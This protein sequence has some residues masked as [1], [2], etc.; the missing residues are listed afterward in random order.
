M[1]DNNNYYEG[2]EPEQPQE[3]NEP[4][5]PNQ[6]SFFAENDGSY[7]MTT[8]E[9][10]PVVLNPV[11]E[12]IRYKKEKKPK[13]WLV[14]AASAIAGALIFSFCAP[15]VSSLTKPLFSQ[16]ESFAF[17]VPQHANNDASV[18]P[19]THSTEDRHQMTAV[20]IGKT[21]GPSIVGIITKKQ[22]QGFFSQQS[23]EENGS[24]IIFTAAGH[25]VTNYHVIEGATNVS[26]VLNNGTEYNATL[27]GSDE[28]T[29]LAVIKIDAPDLTPAVLGDSSSLEAGEMVVAIGNPMGLEFAG[30][31]T[32]GIISA[33]NRTLTVSGRTYKLIQ[34]DA[35]INPGNSGGALVNAY[36]EVIGI[37]S[38]KVASSGVEGMGFAIP[39]SDAKPIIEDLMNNGY[40]T[41]RPL[42]GL[43]VRYIT[44]Q[45]AYY[46]N[47]AT[48][49]L[50]VVEVTPGSGAEAAGIQKGDIVVSCD[51]QEV[52]SSNELNEIRDQHKAGETIHLVINRNGSVMNVD[53]VL[54]EESKT[55]FLR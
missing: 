48:K 28:R 11:H 39:I 23:A 12:N 29:D 10:Y 41:G 19:V 26:V 53:V 55:S 45:E 1:M 31:L 17:S 5:D 46:Y 9:A 30:S 7:R 2:F 34:T 3:A 15:V 33:V 22:Y 52:T 35:A 4:Q 50:V 51:G 24:G 18:T 49:G 42:I 13:I 25:I 38:V 54:G 20:E 6:Q 27:I 43:A 36:G 37:N 8:H 14:A 40:V 44:E 47:F 32:Q 21:V 16:N